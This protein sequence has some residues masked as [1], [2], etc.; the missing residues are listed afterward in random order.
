MYTMMVRLQTKNGPKAFRDFSKVQGGGGTEERP[1][2]IT[3]SFEIWEYLDTHSPAIDVHRE[4]DRYMSNEEFI[5]ICNEDLNKTKNFL[6]EELNQSTQPIQMTIDKWSE[7]V[8]CL[9]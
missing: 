5:A 1:E 7:A 2:P 8:S 6:L 3:Y 9:S 4:Y